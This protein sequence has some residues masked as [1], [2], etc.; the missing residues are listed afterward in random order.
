MSIEMDKPQ[1]CE[2][3]PGLISCFGLMKQIPVSP[4]VVAISQIKWKGLKLSIGSVI[5]DFA[6][7]NFCKINCHCAKVCAQ[8]LR[9]ALPRLGL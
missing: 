7:V 6:I 2:I 8:G 5:I 1:F 9:N 4:D 3:R